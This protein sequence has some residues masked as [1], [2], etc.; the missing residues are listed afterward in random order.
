MRHSYSLLT[1]QEFAVI[2]HMNLEDRIVRAK[3]A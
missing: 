3:V 1:A 2:G